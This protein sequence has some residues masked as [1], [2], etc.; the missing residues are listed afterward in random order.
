MSV[1]N[2]LKQFKDLRAQGK[3]LQSMLANESETANAAGGKVVITLDGNMQMSALAIN[4]ELMNVNSKEKLQNAIK[5]AHNDAL[6]KIQRKVA[7][8]MKDSGDFNIPGLMG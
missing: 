7:I 3:K 6:T 2:K 4:N 8:K 1:F 5:D